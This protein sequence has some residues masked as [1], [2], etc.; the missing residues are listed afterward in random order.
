MSDK[1]AKRASES[2]PPQ[3]LL[4]KATFLLT[5]KKLFLCKELKMEQVCNMLEVKPYSLSKALK[6]QGFCNFAH[7][8]NH[9][10]V[11]EA[12]RMMATHEFNIYTLEAIADM[13][14]FGTRQ[15]FYNAFEKI[16][17]VKP[18]RYRRMAKIS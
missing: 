16:I 4:T 5:Q 13:A 12:K 15:A 11:E 7:F 1:V 18:A 2:I 14:G 6:K 17:G 9:F 8:I 10:R 3:D